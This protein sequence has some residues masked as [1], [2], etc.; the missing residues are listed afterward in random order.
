[1]ASVSFLEQII[2]TLAFPFKDPQWA[3]KLGIGFLLGLGNFIVPLVPALI[4][5]GYSYKIMRRI[6]V[7]NGEPYLPEWEDWGTLLTDGLKLWGAG[8]IYGLPILVLVFACMAISFVPA[9]ALPLLIDSSGRLP[10]DAGLL[11]F[12]PFV[13]CI[14]VMCLAFPLGLAIG[15]FRAPALGH[16]VAKGNFAAAFQIKEYWPIL[17]TGIGAYLIV[18]MATMLVSSVAMM[19]IQLVMLTLILA[20][21]YPLLLGLY[22]FL[23][24]LYTYTFE[25]LAYREGTRKLAG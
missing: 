17:K 19:A 11:I 15:L 24:M 2:Q 14:G 4:L 6:I 1:M 18:I 23:L 3:K 9:M 8:M 20:M 7:E 12:G 10:P 16:M 21:L 13:I 5:S 22:I 25:A